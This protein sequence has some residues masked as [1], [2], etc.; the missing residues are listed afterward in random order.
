MALYC[1]IQSWGTPERI[2]ENLRRRREICGDYEFTL[3]A[4][5][6][7]MPLDVAERSLRLFADE[8]LPELKRW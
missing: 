3:I 7:G 4:H 1:G 5:Y 8:V 6:G 2:L